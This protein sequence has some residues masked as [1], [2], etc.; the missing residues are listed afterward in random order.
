MLISEK[1]LQP[2]AKN[3]F[4][5]LEQLIYQSSLPQA[6]MYYLQDMLRSMYLELNKYNPSYNV[7][8]GKIN[9]ELQLN[10]YVKKKNWEEVVHQALNIK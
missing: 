2:F 3:T 1:T 5:S 4:G 7:V 6:F 9:V 10:H 8:Y